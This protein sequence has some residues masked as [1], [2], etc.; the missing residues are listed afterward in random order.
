MERN[1]GCMRGWDGMGAKC[2][3][4]A[5]WTDHMH[6]DE[7]MCHSV[8]SELLKVSLSCLMGSSWAYLP[9]FHFSCFGYNKLKLICLGVIS[10]ERNII[11]KL[12]D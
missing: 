12:S 8:I 2:P 6:R 9:I 10:D 5:L 11:F 3:Y 4:G 7:I 1:I